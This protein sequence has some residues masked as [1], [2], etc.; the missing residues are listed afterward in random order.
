MQ[1]PHWLLCL[2]YQHVS[3]SHCPIAPF[4]QGESPPAKPQRPCPH[5]GSGTSNCCSSVLPRSSQNA[6]VPTEDGV[7]EDKIERSCREWMGIVVCFRMF[8]LLSVLL[9]LWECYLIHRMWSDIGRLV[10]IS[11]VAVHTPQRHAWPQSRVVHAVK[12]V[13]G[14]PKWAHSVVTLCANL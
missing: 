4:I 7:V 11:I 12:E 9:L 8:I 3:T 10:A 1:N 14:R 6:S 5:I 2:V 13:Q